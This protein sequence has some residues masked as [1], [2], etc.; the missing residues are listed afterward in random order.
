MAVLE[1]DRTAQQ[2]LCHTASQAIAARHDFPSGSMGLSTNEFFS[3]PGRPTASRAVAAGAVL[4]NYP[5]VLL[6]IQQPLFAVST[7]TIFN[8]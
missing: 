1:L 8:S 2:A 4:L 6:R 3:A 5:Q 7:G